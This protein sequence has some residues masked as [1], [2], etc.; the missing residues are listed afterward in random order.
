MDLHVVLNTVLNYDHNPAQW[1]KARLLSRRAKTLVDGKA[2]DKGCLGR[3]SFFKEEWCSICQKTCIGCVLLR[4]IADEHPCRFITH[5]PTWQCR[6]SALYSMIEDY[7]SCGVFL[8]RVPWQ[9]SNKVK[10]PRSSGSITD[11]YC[12]KNCIYLR[13]G[14]YYVHTKWEM[15]GESFVKLV[16]L[17]QYTEEKPKFIF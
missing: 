16:P 4:Y 13:N 17:T 2:Y 8:L 14:Q 9:T 6:M 5:C 3:S 10:I 1:A 12:Q 11:G 15:D 7:K